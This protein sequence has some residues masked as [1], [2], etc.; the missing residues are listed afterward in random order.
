MYYKLSV[1]ILQ[2]LGIKLNN[3]RDR[4]C[5][6]QRDVTVIRRATTPP[7][8]KRHLSI[9]RDCERL[10]EMLQR[11]HVELDRLRSVFDTLWQEKLYRIHVEQDIF[12]SQV[13]LSVS[14]Y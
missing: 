8:A 9:A 12:R 3:L 14:N 2:E 5:D 6:L 7:L 4:L 10:D 1:Y 13:F 11:H